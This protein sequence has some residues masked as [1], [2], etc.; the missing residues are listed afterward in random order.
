M[1]VLTIALAATT[2]WPIGRDFIAVTY[3]Y[4]KE[5]VEERFLGLLVD[6][7]GRIIRPKLI[8]YVNTIYIEIILVY[9][10]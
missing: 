2:R 1:R 5:E 6:S 4:I 7:L 8:H 3:N 10:L 9:K